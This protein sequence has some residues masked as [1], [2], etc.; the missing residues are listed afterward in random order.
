M[1]IIK[2]FFK[3][4]GCG[5]DFILFDERK[6]GSIFN[7]GLFKK[8]CDRHFGI[9]ADG[10]LFLLKGSKS[11]CFMRIFNADGTEAEMCGNGIRCFVK[12]L[13]DH[14]K[15]RENPVQVETKSGL[16]TCEYKLDQHFNVSEVTVS[17]G[18]PVFKRNLIPVAGEGDSLDIKLDIGGKEFYINGVNTGTPHAVIF[19]DF[20]MEDAVRYGSVISEH[21]MFPARTNVEFVKKITDKEF[22]CIVYERGCGITMACGT[23]ASASIAVACKK[24]FAE[25]C[26]DNTVFLPGGSLSIRVTEDFS[27]IFMTGPATEVFI[28]EIR[29]ND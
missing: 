23:G 20:T 5:N 16:K 26:V 2:K 13:V 11:P 6:T 14:L 3:Y 1:E 19:S 8:L 7:P 9:G 25:T 29:L 17:M 21:P 15:I 22:Q 28:G 12:Y 24:G 18:A 4:E 10:I 27:D